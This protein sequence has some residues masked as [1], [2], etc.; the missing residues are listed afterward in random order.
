MALPSI[1]LLVLFVGSVLYLSLQVFTSILPELPHP[2]P[3]ASGSPPS[4]DAAALAVAAI[5]TVALTAMHYIRFH[6]PITIA[7]GAAV[8]CLLA[9]GVVATVVPSI[10]ET[11]LNVLL[12]VCGLAVFALAMRFDMSDPQRLTRRTDIAFWLH[13]L[14]APL[15][16]HPLIRGLLHGLDLEA[17]DQ[18]GRRHPVDLRRARRGRRRHRPPG[19]PRVRPRLCRHRLQRVDPRLG[20]DDADLSHPDRPARAR[21]LH[22]ADQ[23]RLAAAA[24]RPLLRRLPRPLAAAA[25]APSRS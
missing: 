24:P 16:V 7:A 23:R 2:V 6:V 17:H 25:P 20:P 13:L 19:D 4:S 11:M 21:R 22:P 3:A 15:I 10:D 8:L 14:A 5:T 9:V 1:V 12:L 18:R